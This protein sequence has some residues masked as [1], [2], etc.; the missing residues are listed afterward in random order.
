MQWWIDLKNDQ[1]NVYDEDRSGRPFILTDELVM[2]IDKKFCENCLFT[3]TEPSEHFYQISRSLVHEDV[4]GK[5]GFHKF[6]AR[7]ISK[8]LTEDQ[9]KQRLAAA[10]AFM[11]EYDKKE[12]KVV[13][14][15][16]TGNETWVKHVNT[17]KQN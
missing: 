15:I 2:K 4:I 8:I 3:I 9:K 10:L 1:T 16:S 13:N 17:V 7:W 6:C 14:C 5:L 12:N 11:D